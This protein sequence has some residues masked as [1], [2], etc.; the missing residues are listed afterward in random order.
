MLNCAAADT[1]ALPPVNVASSELMLPP[2]EM[3]VW[4]MTKPP[5][6]LVFVQSLVPELKFP[7]ITKLAWAG[8]TAIN[9][10]TPNPT[11]NFFCLVFIF[12]SFMI[13]KFTH[14][15]KPSAT[16]RF[17]L[18]AY[19]PPTLPLM[20]LY[21]V[22][23]ELLSQFGTCV[24]I[25]RPSSLSEPIIAMLLG[26]QEL[27]PYALSQQ[28]Y[29]KSPK[30]A[31]YASTYAFS[32]YLQGKYGDALKVMQQLTPKDLASPSIAGYYGIILKANGNKAEAK[33]Y[34]NRITKAQ[35]LPEEQTLFDQARAGL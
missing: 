19:W 16:H 34:L 8:N 26:A 9:P 20:Q 13:Y 12:I 1:P 14:F 29:Q 4:L 28:V 21:L 10:A 6:L 30:N 15:K 24:I 23:V 35:L 5:P 11:N 33:S 31:P 3:P 32:L 18:F 7:F 17:N 27:N 2:P 25:I 22:H